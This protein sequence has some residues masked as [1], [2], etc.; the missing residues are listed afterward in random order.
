MASNF[1]GFSKTHS[2]LNVLINSS[3]TAWS[4]KL[5]CHFAFL[6]QFQDATATKLNQLQLDSFLHNWLGWL[7]REMPQHYPLPWW[8]LCLL[9]IVFSVDYFHGFE[10]VHKTY[11]ILIW[12]LFYFFFI[13]SPICRGKYK[14]P[15]VLP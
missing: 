10:I 12:S 11:L 4:A 3:R 15:P 14:Y 7:Y 9:V 1:F 8:N 5:K 6:K 2:I 13:L